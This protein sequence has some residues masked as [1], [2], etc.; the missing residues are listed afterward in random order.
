MSRSF[1][2]RE[3]V[4]YSGLFLGL[5]VAMSAALYSIGKVGFGEVG[6]SM[7]SVMAMPDVWRE[8]L[9]FREV[10]QELDNI[11]VYRI[12]TF[13][14]AVWLWMPGIS[15]DQDLFD[16]PFMRTAKRRRKINEKFVL[17]GPGDDRLEYDA[18]QIV[19]ALIHAVFVMEESSDPDRLNFLGALGISKEFPNWNGVVTLDLVRASIFALEDTFRSTVIARMGFFAAI[20][21]GSGFREQARYMAGF[22]YMDYPDVMKARV[23]SG[24]VLPRYYEMVL[25]R[26]GERLDEVL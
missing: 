23:E 20:L 6:G 13:V 11:V 10:D 14:K 9:D 7:F 8:W 16:A 2:T 12:N 15:R 18:R 17:E 22:V 24:V 26:A 25:A 3:V 21:K 5:G 1:K 4:G 19:S